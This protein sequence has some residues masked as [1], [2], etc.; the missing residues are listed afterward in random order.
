MTSAVLNR[1]E[2][3]FMGK[4]PFSN[5][6]LNRNPNPKKQKNSNGRLGDGSVAAGL[7]PQSA[8]DDASS[9]CRNVSMP[10]RSG[11]FDQ[12]Q[13][14]TLN[15]GSYSR[16]EGKRL[17][18][19]LMMELDQVRRWA[20]RLDSAE[21]PC[22][23]TSTS[24]QNL[25]NRKF[26]SKK[27]SGTK[28]PPEK[29]IGKS[30]KRMAVVSPKLMKMCRQVLTK[31]M[32]HKL[33]WIFNTPVDVVGMKLHDYYQIVNK[34]M[35]LGTVKSKLIQNMYESPMEFADDVRLTFN[36]ALLYNPKGH[37]VHLI[38]EQLLAMFE[39][40]FRPISEEYEFEVLQYQQQMN[41]PKVYSDEELPQSSWNYNEVSRTPDKVPAC[42]IGVID[43]AREPELPQV[44]ARPALVDV[45]VPKPERFQVQSP[46]PTQP[47][48]TVSPVKPLPRAKLPKPKAKDLDKRE[49]S[50][51]EKIKLGAELQA[52]PDEKM[53]Q[54][55]QIVQKR[56]E[57]VIEDGDEVELDI[58]SL[59]TET[60]WELD[61]FVVNWKKAVSKMKRQGLVGNSGTA[62]GDGQDMVVSDDAE[63]NTGG[64]GEGGKAK[65]GDDED[66]D[67]GDEMPMSN[68]PPVIIEKD[69]GQGNGSRSSSSSGS[70]TGSDSS[71][72][73]DSDSG[74]SSG[75]ESDAEVA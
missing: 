40:L 18:K 48:R 25:P 42:D 56:N 26:P 32:K 10:S 29:S 41:Y 5:P 72:S 64:Y 58:E 34:P 43:S 9:Y 45:P 17:K 60:L 62:P 28:R 46:V 55:L 69:D 71:S 54:L 75:S 24:S 59:D 36:N 7:Q 6:H 33:G 53:A 15:M 57:H 51:E 63:V 8:P 12:G 39:G 70:S 13:Y 38:A 23:G 19:R 44:I 11:Q 67:I 4:S 3:T 73:S 14:L 74:S 16:S 68:F 1:N 22:V 31:L 27:I 47:H 66:V 37:D 52:L 50:N 35:D 20:S 61:R 2:S 30:S 21:Q 49:M 65:T